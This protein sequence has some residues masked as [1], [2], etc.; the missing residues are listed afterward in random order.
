M[1]T[2]G[3][4]M[5]NPVIYCT[6]LDNV[7]EAALLMKDHGIGAVPVYEDGSLIGIITD[8]DIAI[9]GVGSKHPGSTKVT[10]IMSE[11]MATISSGESLDEAASL[12]ASRQ[13]RRLPV[14]EN[15]ECVGI[16]S[17]GDLARHMD[18]SATTAGVLK[19][20]SQS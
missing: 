18:G 3:D 2:V 6:T 10:D 8:R 1:I 13:V 11:G 4:V 15:G 9:R 14:I 20:I 16:L 17:L 7:Y 19:D 5:S 12:M